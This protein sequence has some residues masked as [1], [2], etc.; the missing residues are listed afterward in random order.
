MGLYSGLFCLIAYDCEALLRRSLA[1]SGDHD[2]NG[3]YAH[4]L[5]S[6][7]SLNSLSI[8]MTDAGELPIKISEKV[9]ANRQE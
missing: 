7:Q 6:F 4:T 3:R 5:T 9:I 8:L 2:P 1:E